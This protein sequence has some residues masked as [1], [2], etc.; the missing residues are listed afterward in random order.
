MSSDHRQP[1][2]SQH[3]IIAMDSRRFPLLA[4]FS[5]LLGLGLALPYSVSARASSK[6]AAAGN[7]LTTLLSRAPVTTA[8]WTATARAGRTTTSSARSPRERSTHTDETL[9][10]MDERRIIRMSV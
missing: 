10:H 2:P 5:A 3:G 9:N 4:E 7:S 6:R 1:N 8:A